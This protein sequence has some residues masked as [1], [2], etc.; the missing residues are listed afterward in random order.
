M[1]ADRS[2]IIFMRRLIR[3]VCPKFKIS[4]DLLIGVSDIFV[5]LGGSWVRI[6]GGSSEDIYFLR[7]MIKNLSRNMGVTKNRRKKRKG[8]T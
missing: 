6:F 3:T 8:R 7:K 2:D 4:D 1:C 5:S